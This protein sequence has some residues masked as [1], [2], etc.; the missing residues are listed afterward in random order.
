MDTTFS[1][2]DEPPNVRPPKVAPEATTP[3]AS[4]AIEPRLCLTGIRA[5]SSRRML[6]ADS[7]ERTS[8]R[9]TTREPIQTG[10]AHVCTPG[11]NAHHELQSLVEQKRNNTRQ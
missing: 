8:K 4:R 11:T 5:S 10:S 1:A 3:G 6:V 7:E 9:L 2:T